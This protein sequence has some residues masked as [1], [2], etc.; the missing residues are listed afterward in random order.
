MKVQSVTEISESPRMSIARPF[1]VVDGFTKLKPVKEV[2][3]IVVVDDAFTNK[4]F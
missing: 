1:H 3:S 2:P 4:P